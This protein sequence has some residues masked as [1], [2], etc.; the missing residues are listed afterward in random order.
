[1]KPI[2][3]LGKMGNG[4]TSDGATGRSGG[5]TYHPLFENMGLVISPNVQ[6]RA[7]GARERPQVSPDFRVPPSLVNETFLS[8]PRQ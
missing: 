7:Y 5:G 6:T 3:S 2:N 4:V 8:R 1:M